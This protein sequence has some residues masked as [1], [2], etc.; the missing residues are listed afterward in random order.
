MTQANTS[1]IALRLI[2]A[3]PFVGTVARDIA[4]GVENVYYALV[5]LVTVVILAVQTWGLVA[6]AMTALM[7]VPVMFILLLLITRG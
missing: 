7:A 3:V 1:A 5:I 6:L 2:H 4:K